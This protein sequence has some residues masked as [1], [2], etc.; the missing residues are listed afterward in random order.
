MR[1]KFLLATSLMMLMAPR[2]L[3]AA[4]SGKAQ[5]T[6]KSS[7]ND[8]DKNK[9]IRVSITN[10]SSTQDYY[11]RLDDLRLKGAEYVKNGEGLGLKIPV[12]T[13]LLTLDGEATPARENRFGVTFGD[14]N[15]ALAKRFAKPAATKK[16]VAT[17]A[18]SSP[19]KT[20]TVSAKAA[21]TTTKKPTS[22]PAPSKT[23]PPPPAPT[24]PP[25]KPST[26]TAPPPA[27]EP[28]LDTT[29]LL[30]PNAPPLLTDADL[31]KAKAENDTALAAQGQ[32]PEME[33]H[34]YSKLL[35]DKF[36]MRSTYLIDPKTGKPTLDS[37][38]KPKVFWIPNIDYQGDET[39]IYD[40][41]PPNS[42]RKVK[43]A[44]TVPFHNV[45]ELTADYKDENGDVLIKKGEK[46]YEVEFDNDRVSF[47]RADDPNGT[48]YEAPRN[49]FVSKEFQRPLRVDLED[50]R[51]KSAAFQKAIADD[52]GMDD[53]SEGERN[54]NSGTT[55]AAED[56]DPPT[57]HDKKPAPVTNK[58]AKG[59]RGPSKANYARDCNP[60]S[61]KVGKRNFDKLYAEKQSFS[62]KTRR[63]YKATILAAAYEQQIHPAII[64]ASMHLETDFNPAKEN[65]T[66][67]DTVGGDESKVN[68]AGKRKSFWGKGLGQIGPAECAS[69]VPPIIWAGSYDEYIKAGRKPENSIWNPVTAIKGKA[70][71]MRMKLDEAKLQAA[72]RK[73]N[74]EEAI[75][76]MTNR[77]GEEGVAEQAR[78][79]ISM[80]NRGMMSVNSLAYFVNHDSEKKYPKYYGQVW[81][82]G[83]TKRN[84]DLYLN[85]HEINRAHIYRAAGL[86]GGIRPNSLMARYMK[87]YKESVDS[88]GKTVWTSAV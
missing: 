73:I 3:L 33:T 75:A 24:P 80:F 49:K 50:Y 42:S 31:A 21:S 74:A 64:E 81:S 71:L 55:T 18:K 25:P 34:P 72:K 30:S 20:V 14:I 86:C 70:R 32:T 39:V 6:P 47:A 22:S 54:T 13:P 77:P 12:G 51:A 19:P 63:Q 69:M 48:V 28:E 46:I 16:K 53:D 26:N 45:S 9:T 8:K 84:Y 85:G 29:S 59:L 41:Y 66:E 78:Y 1:L 5:S 57:D 60:K 82:S 62:L 65:V 68:T 87:E 11:V 2:V 43:K 44:A 7:A 88:K 27:P 10:E 35:A 52:G 36:M 15:A 38:G 4:K 67:K 79:I 76:Y 40:I 23:P 17:V 37:K 58:A 83:P 61:G 56:E